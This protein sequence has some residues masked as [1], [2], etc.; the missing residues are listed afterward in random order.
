MSTLFL[1]DFGRG[2]LAAE[3]ALLH[4]LPD[5]PGPHVVATEDAETTLRLAPGVTPLLPGQPTPGEVRRAVLLGPQANVNRAYNQIRRLGALRERGLAT[6]LRNIS[7][8]PWGPLYRPDE[9]AMAAL[10]GLERASARDH[11][12]LGS[13]VEWR[14]PWWPAFDAFPEAAD[15]PELPAVLP[16][17]P[18]LGLS[19]RDGERPREA[20][21]RCAE[22]VAALCAPYR[23]W[24]VVPLPMSRTDEAE[25][26]RATLNFAAEFLPGSPVAAEAA[27]GDHGE[28]RR[29]LTPARLKG[30]VASCDAVVAGRDLIV[31]YAASAG[32]PCLALACRADDEAG[33]AAGTLAN[34]LAP[35]SRYVALPS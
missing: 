10:L 21:A 2:D 28:W 33:R 13:M 14:C 20:F 4:A 5:L 17:G 23:G 24:T 35:G 19:I 26:L 22:Q 7:F 12:T 34:T 9:P 11:R 30:W 27:P 25:D 16:P 29:A 31:A 18:R 15:T 32:V 8:H 6:E 1:G 3:A